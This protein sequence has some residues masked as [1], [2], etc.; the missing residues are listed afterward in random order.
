V[1]NEKEMK[2]KI[3]YIRVDLGFTLILQSGIQQ[4]NTIL[5]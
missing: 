2:P 1:K 4:N 3:K 5:L